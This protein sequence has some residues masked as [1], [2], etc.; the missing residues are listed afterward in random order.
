[1]ILIDVLLLTTVE[2][3]LTMCLRLC[4]Q[5]LPFKPNREEDSV[6]FSIA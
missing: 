4:C 3:I 2:H 1:M 6:E 5:Y